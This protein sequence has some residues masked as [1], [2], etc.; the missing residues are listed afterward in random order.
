MCRTGRGVVTEKTKAQLDRGNR[1]VE[2][3]KQP[4]FNPIP[5]E[6]QVAT[7]WALQKDYYATIDTEKVTASAANLRE[8]LVTRKADLLVRIRETAKVTD[9][10]EAELKTAC[11]EWASAQS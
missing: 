8:F 3:F 6:E 4:A 11:D 10:I 2:L 5:I 7:L 1:I 9:E